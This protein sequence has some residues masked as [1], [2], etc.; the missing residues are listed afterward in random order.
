MAPTT[1]A[2]SCAPIV[3]EVDRRSGLRPVLYLVEDGRVT[4]LMASSRRLIATG[5]TPC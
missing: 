5:V 3:N 4:C 2:G 1:A